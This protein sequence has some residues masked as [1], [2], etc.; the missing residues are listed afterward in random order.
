VSSKV[1]EEVYIM[2][3][4]LHFFQR[5]WFQIFTGGLLL[6]IATEESFR[7]TQNP[8]FF[9]TVILLG[10]LLVPVSFIAYV[11]ERIPAKEISLSCI[12]ICF[13]GGGAVGLIAAGL[14]EFEAIQKMSILALILVGLIEE[15]AKLIFPMVQYVRGKY[16]SE[17]DGLLFGV[18]AGM[19]FA[20]LETMGYGLVV[21]IQSAG[22]VG[23]LE[24][25]LLIRGLLS[26][27]GHAAWTGF[28][29][30]VMWRERTRKGRGLLSLSVIGAF[31]LA[32]VLHTLWDTVNSLGVTTAG[33]LV[34]VIIGNVAIAAISL[35]LLMRR[36]REAIRYGESAAA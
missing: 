24:Q 13:L 20:A 19:G 28:L 32:I 3:D 22:N 16:R 30:A 1:K 34:I 9:P 5:R 35:T 15:S 29:C 2:T 23:T 25:V 7:I 21:L 4:R 18:A 27:A 31:V 17:A 33:G 14:L 12:L 8:N 10:A 36:M 11:Y 6:F 26:P